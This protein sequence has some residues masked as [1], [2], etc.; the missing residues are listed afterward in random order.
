MHTIRGAVGLD[1]CVIS[2]ALLG[3]ENDEQDRNDG[4][5][6]DTDNHD[7][8]LLLLFMRAEDL[9][10]AFWDGEI[11]AVLELLA[12]LLLLGAGVAIDAP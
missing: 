7:V 11:L 3:P 10:V 1:G 6:D 4:H 8:A 9:A 2:C 5:Y 12:H